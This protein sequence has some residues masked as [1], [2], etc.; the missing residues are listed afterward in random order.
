MYNIKKLL[1]PLLKYHT[2]I[3]NDSYMKIITIMYQAMFLR[4][5]KSIT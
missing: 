5:T 4:M 2:V 1:F 3:K